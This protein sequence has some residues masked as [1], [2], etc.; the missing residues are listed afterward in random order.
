MTA[1][2]LNWH[3]LPYF[4]P[5]GHIWRLEMDADTL[6]RVGG[7]P[8]MSQARRGQLGYVVYDKGYW[9]GRVELV[10][11]NSSVTPRRRSADAAKADV[12]AMVAAFLAAKDRY[13]TARQ[14]ALDAVAGHIRDNPPPRVGEPLRR[15]LVTGRDYSGAGFVLYTHGPNAE[16]ACEEARRLHPDPSKIASLEAIEVAL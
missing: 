11:Y 5:P 10:P 1:A 3:E 14:I 12:E 15:W 2:R 13:D 6:A 7:A 9:S 4:R 16:E 8:C